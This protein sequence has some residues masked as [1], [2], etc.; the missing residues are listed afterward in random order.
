MAQPAHSRPSPVS[1]RLTNL[2][3]TAQFYWW[4]GHVVVL[5]FGVMYYLKRMLG[6]SSANWYY[7]SAYMGALLSYTIRDIQDNVEYLLLAF[8]WFTQRAIVVTLLP[9]V[10][11]SLFHVITYSR[12]TLIPIFFPGVPAEL[13]AARQANGAPIALSPAARYQQDAGRA[14]LEVGVW[15]VA[16]VGTWLTLGAITF[17]TPLLAP[18]FYAQFLRFRFALSAPTRQA[19]RRVRTFLDRVLV[20]PQASANVPHVVTDV[21]VKGR[22]ILC[23]M[24]A[25]IMDP[26]ANQQQQQQQQQ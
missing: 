14:E 16:V 19:F 10:V 17:Q 13:Q 23:R 26:T 15:E 22:D 25:M 3:Q 12:S 9:F 8:Y 5:T 4:I 1:V 2:A 20:P 11:F 7:S 21:Y 6:A 18:I 24:G